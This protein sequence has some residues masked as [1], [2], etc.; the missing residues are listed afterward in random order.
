LCNLKGALFFFADLYKKIAHQDIEIDFLQTSSYGFG[1]SPT[2]TEVLRSFKDI[3]TH[4]E[5]KDILIIDDIMDTGVTLDTLV[6]EAKS[7]SKKIASIRTCVLI[8]KTE[9]RKKKSIKPDYSGFVVDKGYLVGYGLG[10]GDRYRTLP[11]IHTI[12]PEGKG[13]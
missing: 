9:R 4:L 8:N 13:I 1:T 5:G 7:F 10:V 11:D 2:Q 6:K 12:V 3:T